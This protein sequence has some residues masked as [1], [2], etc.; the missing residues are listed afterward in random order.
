MLYFT[1][2]KELKE[3]ISMAKTLCKLAEKEIKK[4]DIEKMN[5]VCKKCNLKSSKEKKLCKPQ[6]IK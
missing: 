2:N 5:F 6:K 1:L 3:L 4:L